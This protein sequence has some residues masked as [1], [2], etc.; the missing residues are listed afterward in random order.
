MTN[1]TLIRPKNTACPAILSGI[2]SGA[3]ES[4]SEE[5]IPEGGR[6][7]LPLFIERRLLCAVRECRQGDPPLTTHHRSRV[8]TTSARLVKTRARAN[9]SHTGQA[10]HWRAL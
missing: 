7:S 6:M 1:G 8:G 3:N 2:H 10:H 4:T 9:R 5:C